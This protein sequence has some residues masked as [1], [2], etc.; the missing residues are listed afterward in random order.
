M[1]MLE[2]KLDFALSSQIVGNLTTNLMLPLGENAAHDIV[3]TKTHKIVYSFTSYF[4]N[5]GKALIDQSHKK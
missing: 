1:N 4:I 2:A 3:D 5:H